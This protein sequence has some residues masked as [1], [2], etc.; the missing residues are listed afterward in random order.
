MHFQFLILALAL[1]PFEAATAAP[2]D[3]K[4]VAKLIDQLG[5]SQFK[6]REAATQALNALG[7]PALPSLRQA[8]QGQDPEIR[9]R[10]EILALQIQKRAELAQIL[11]PKRVHLVLKDAT[12]SEAVADLA[13]KTGFPIR[14]EGAAKNRGITLDTGNTTFW[15]AF[16]HL[17]QEGGLVERVPPAV[18]GQEVRIWNARGGAAGQMVVVDRVSR[19]SGTPADD[20]LTLAP[21]TPRPYR[22]YYAGAV[23]I[24]ALPPTDKAWGQGKDETVVIFEITPQPKLSWQGTTEVR[25]DK[26]LD[27][28]GQTLLPSLTNEASFAESVARKMGNGVVVVDSETGRTVTNSREYPV[29]LKRADKRSRVLKEVKGA[30]TAQVRT[31]PQVLVTVDNL[32]KATGQTIKGIEGTS[33]KVVEATRQTGNLQLKLHLEGPPDVVGFAANQRV[34]RRNRIV[35]RNGMIREAGAASEPTFTLVDE[36]GHNLSLQMNE[37]NWHINGN[38]VVQEINAVCRHHI[39]EGDPV[40]LVYSNRRTLTIEVPFTLKDVALP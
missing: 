12:I 11:E 22:T 4:Q 13:G 16:D 5:S 33:I 6:V 17:C 3:S 26:A 14:L 8:A 21:G 25:I 31:P 37:S 7:E 27:D 29:R 9:H 19:M 15:E 34:M 30:V 18:H 24:R 10:A 2:L 32:L 20:H 38:H 1:G 23:R 36:D 39:N 35:I 28:Q 40:K